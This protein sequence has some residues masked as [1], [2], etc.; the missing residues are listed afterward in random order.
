MED[1]V[2]KIRNCQIIIII[3]DCECLNNPEYDLQIKKAIELQKYFI[4]VRQITIPLKAFTEKWNILIT[5]E[6]TFINKPKE[7][8]RKL[9]Q[10]L[11]PRHLLYSSFI[12]G[13]WR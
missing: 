13:K 8:H 3:G 12:I 10:F 9:A 5:K 11:V 7:I 4:L 1:F 6:L 2:E